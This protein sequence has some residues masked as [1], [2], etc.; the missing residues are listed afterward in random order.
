[1]EE[2]TYSICAIYC[3]LSKM[4]RLEG[5][6]FRKRLISRA[7]GQKGRTPTLYQN[8]GSFMCML[9]TKDAEK[10]NSKPMCFEFER[11]NKGAKY[12]FRRQAETERC[13]LVLTCVRTPVIIQFGVS[14]LQRG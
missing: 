10:T 12:S 8:W 9:Y 2:I 6:F 7:F 5:P 3:T 1:M 4:I 14:Y 13:E 11:K